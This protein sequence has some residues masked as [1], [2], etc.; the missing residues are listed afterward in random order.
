LDTLGLLAGFTELYALTDRANPDVGGR[1]TTHAY[2][3]GDPFAEDDALPDGDATARD[4]WL[5]VAKVALVDLDRMHRR[6]DDVLVDTATLRAGVAVPGATVGV[7]STA[8]A[9]VILR[10]A[11]RAL[12]SQLTLYANST[13]D[14]VPT[15]TALDATSWR[16][17]PMGESVVQRLTRLLRAQAELLYTRL[18]DATGRTQSGWNAET[19]A[20]IGTGADLE[21]HAAAIRGLL[22]AYLATGETR[23]RDRALA[24]FE[25]TDATFWDSAARSYRTNTA[26]ERRWT[27]DRFGVVQAALR[28]MY[29]LIGS[30]PG[31]EA[32]A[33]RVL[34]RLTRLNKLVLNGW[35]DANDDG[36]VQWPFEC[37][38]VVD[39]LP[40]GGLL[41]S[42][43]ALTGELGVRGPMSTSDRDHDCVPE[44]DDAQLASTL[45]GE[46]VFEVR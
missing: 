5:A 16:G 9:V 11:R 33:T 17:A 44:I 8:Y 40:R 28:E 38:R 24:V 21:A 1:Q 36:V 25:R 29:K 19:G 12:T 31:S 22:E 39:G 13:P 10:S 23:Y 37:S 41:L 6:S 42:E 43:R 27:P 18:T 2:F 4:R 15:T 46:I 20:V 14:A 35:D 26:G 7:R 34:V 3:D 45:A 32:L 30:R